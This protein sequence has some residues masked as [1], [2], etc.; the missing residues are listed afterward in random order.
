MV[1]KDSCFEDVL[2]AVVKCCV[3]E[4]KLES[5]LGLGYSFSLGRILVAHSV[6]LA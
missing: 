3:L 6:L 5:Q 4:I 1:I 2:R